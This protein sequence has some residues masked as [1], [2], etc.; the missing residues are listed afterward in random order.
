M[1]TVQRSIIKIKRNFDDAN[2]SISL[3][4]ISPDEVIISFRR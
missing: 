1:E 4:E 3:D 2:T